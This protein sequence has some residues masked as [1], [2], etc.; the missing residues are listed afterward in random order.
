MSSLL[1][2][3]IIGLEQIKCLTETLSLT[4][5]LK[6]AS[7]RATSADFFQMIH[8]VFLVEALQSYR[9]HVLLRYSLEKKFLSIS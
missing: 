1:A 3:F 4:L 7:F 2:F 6:A 8:L 9:D 5:F